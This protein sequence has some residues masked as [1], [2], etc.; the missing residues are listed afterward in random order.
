MAE[1]DGQQS[2][3][4]LPAELRRFERE[5]DNRP[6]FRKTLGRALSATLEGNNRRAAAYLAQLDPKDLYTV[7]VA[8]R[9]LTIQAWRMDKP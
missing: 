4:D 8:C 3:F 7:R 5:P 2:M 1:M 9:I 6:D